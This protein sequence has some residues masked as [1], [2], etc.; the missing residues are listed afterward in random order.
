M[1]ILIFETIIW[2]KLFGS[3]ALQK[4]LWIAVLWKEHVLCGIVLSGT[5]RRAEHDGRAG[6]VRKE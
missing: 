1:V 4:L 2:A 6:E 3:N 5:V